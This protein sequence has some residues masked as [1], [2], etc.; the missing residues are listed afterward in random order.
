MKCIKFPLALVCGN[1][2]WLQ[3]YLVWIVV[4][5][6]DEKLEWLK[7]WLGCYKI[8]ALYENNSGVTYNDAGT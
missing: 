5:E 8:V 6:A 3:E 4:A 7:D 1:Q 2:W